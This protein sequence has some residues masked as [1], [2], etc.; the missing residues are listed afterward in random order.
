MSLIRFMILFPSS[1]TIIW[2]TPPAKPNIS[3]V[4]SDPTSRPRNI[5]LKTLKRSPW[6]T[7]TISRFFF[8]YLIKKRFQSDPF[9]PSAFSIRKKAVINGFFVTFKVLPQPLY[10]FS[11]APSEIAFSQF[12]FYDRRNLKPWC[13]PVCSLFLKNRNCDAPGPLSEMLR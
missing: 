12:L 3:H 2:V 10:R 1:L 11:A 9:I 7:M 5:E 13:N 4:F 8:H 6:K